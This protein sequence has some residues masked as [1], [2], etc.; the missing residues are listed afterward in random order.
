MDKGDEAFR[1]G[2]W[3]QAQRNYKRALGL[4]PGSAHI[5]D[6]IDLVGNVSQQVEAARANIDAAIQRQNWN[7]AMSLARDLDRYIEEIKSMVR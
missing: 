4:N 3:Q 1:E 6:R 7:K 5:E 2:H